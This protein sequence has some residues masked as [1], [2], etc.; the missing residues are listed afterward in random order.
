MVAAMALLFACSTAFAPPSLLLSSRRP[1]SSRS[2]GAAMQTLP[3]KASELMSLLRTKESMQQISFQ[4]T[5]DVVDELFD[6]NEVAFSVGDVAS[7]AGQ[8]MGSAKIFSFGKMNELEKGTTLQLFGDFYR[9]DVLENPEGSDHANIRAF[10]KG[11][12]DAVSFPDGYAL[13]PK[14]LDNDYMA[15]GPSLGSEYRSMS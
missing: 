13:T 8:N 14:A 7:A 11:G 15:G 9:K 12:W 3:P 6:V 2:P 10:I 1:G 5:M 4:L